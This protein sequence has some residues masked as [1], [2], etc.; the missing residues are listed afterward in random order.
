[1]IEANRFDEI[2]SQ[3]KSLKP[4]LVVGDV[5]IDKYTIGEVK[6]ISPEAPVPV[7]EVVREW[8]KLG[9][10]ANVIDNLNSLEVQSTIC[11]VVGNDRNADHL[12]ALLEDS[13][14]S[15]WGIVRCPERMTTF[16]E[17]IVTDVQQIC[18]VDYET[19]DNL[20][21]ESMKSLLH[22]VSEFASSHSAVILED[23][24]KGLF[25]KEFTSE[26]IK[27][28]RSAG[29]FIA[30]DPSRE[31]NPRFYKG[32]DL[33]KPNKVESQLMAHALGHTTRDIDEISKILMGEL[34]LKQLIIT[35]GGEGMAVTEQSGK[36]SRIPTVAREVFDVS[37]AGDTAISTIVAALSSGASLEEAAWIGNCASGVVVGKKGTALVTQSELKKFYSELQ[38]V[39]R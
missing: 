30:V 3:F 28:I 39:S 32:A 33:L 25:C 23:Y 12:E 22:R 26:A 27:M 16:K 10:A 34:E 18:R 1:M 21:E 5:G 7:V 8:N 37:G 36:T 29:A 9:L 24:N 11:G 38:S 14:L 6:R 20:I 15:T 35:L 4:I 19:T 13:K 17:R 31:T 2:I